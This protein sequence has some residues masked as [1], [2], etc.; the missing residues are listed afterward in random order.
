[1]KFKFFKSCAAQFRDSF[2]HGS[3]NMLKDTAVIATEFR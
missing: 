3:S 2:R 1:M